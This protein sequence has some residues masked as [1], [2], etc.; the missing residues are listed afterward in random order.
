MEKALLTVGALVILTATAPSN[1]LLAQLQRLRMPRIFTTT[2]MLCFRYLSLLAG[3]ASDMTRAYHLRSAKQTGL[4]LRHV[5]S[6]I[7]QLLLRSI[8]RAERVYAAMQCRGFDG[9]FPAAETH[10]MERVSMRYAILVSLALLLLRMI[11]FSNVL[12]WIGTRLL[13]A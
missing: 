6:F 1:R 9:T 4:E 3:E 8:D 11:G 10:M 7:G 12:T 5:G 13:G 2:V